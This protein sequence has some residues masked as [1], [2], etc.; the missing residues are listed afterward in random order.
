MERHPLR[1]DELRRQGRRAGRRRSPVELTFVDR[2]IVGRLQEAEAAVE[3]GFAEYRFDLAA[4]AI[5]ELVWDEYCDWYVELA[6]VQLQTGSSSKRGPAQSGGGAQQR[7][8][9]RTLVRVLEAILRLAH[10]II[11]FITEE[12]W[13]KVA[14]L[15]GEHGREHHARAL[16]AGPARNQDRPGRDR[17]VALLKELVNACRTLR[18]R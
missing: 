11:P 9:R 8:T 15:A 5:Y 2:W 1:A 4:R 12:L 18:A 7:G 13:Q 3:A 14:P 16:S 6:K 10:P 17:Q